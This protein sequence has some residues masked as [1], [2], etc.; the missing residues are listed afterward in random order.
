MSTLIRLIRRFNH[1]LT[2]RTNIITQVCLS[3]VNP[4]TLKHVH[5]FMSII[6][7]IDQRVQKQYHLKKSVFV[8]DFDL[9]HTISWFI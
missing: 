2:D 8:S 9:L 5:K 3:R 7:K 1:I 4:Q 6:F